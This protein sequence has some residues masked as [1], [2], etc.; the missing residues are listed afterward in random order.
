V[1]PFR[2]VFDQSLVGGD[3]LAKAARIA[4]KPRAKMRHVVVV[5]SRIESKTAAFDRFTLS[6]QM[7]QL[8]TETAGKACIV[9]A[10]HLG[11]VQIVETNVQFAAFQR[12]HKAIGLD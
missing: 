2:P 5:R 4:E 9:D 8:L 6:S 12:A 7:K 10:R 11:T 3:R 1:D